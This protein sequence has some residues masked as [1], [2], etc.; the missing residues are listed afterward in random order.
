MATVYAKDQTFDASDSTPVS[1]PGF[2]AWVWL[3]VRF[4]VDELG[5]VITASST[6]IA[7]DFG[8]A[9]TADD[10]DLW[11]DETK[12]GYPYAWVGL[13][14]A[15]RDLALCLGAG[16]SIY[17]WT[18][19][20]AYGGQYLLAGGGDADTMPTVAGEKTLSAAAGLNSGT[21]V[22]QAKG[23][24]TTGRFKFVA[25]PGAGGVAG[26]AGVFL[27]LV[28]LVNG[29]AGAVDEM[30]VA[31]V[32]TLPTRTTLSDESSGV[33]WALCQK[34]EAGEELVRCKMLTVGSIPGSASA[35]P[36]TAEKPIAYIRVQRDASPADLLGRC[37]D[38][39][40]TGW[41]CAA[42][43]TGT[44]STTRDQLCTGPLCFGWDG[45]EPL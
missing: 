14:H 16:A 2:G 30:L 6:R 38:L 39:Y 33:C 5:W 31:S 25:Y 45:S 27:A 10:D 15:G 35:S 17:D 8:N 36:R 37:V 44:L 21:F 7:L 19:K 34:G 13:Y 18:L 1:F 40:W 12:A 32:P 42:V 26:A 23:D 22:V 3:F 28:Q 11:S 43:E 20:G 4:L 24:S 9:D 29:D 41:A